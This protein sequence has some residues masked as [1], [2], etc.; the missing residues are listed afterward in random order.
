MND[1]NCRFKVG[2]VV[3]DGLGNDVCIVAVRS[4]HAHRHPIVGLCGMKEEIKSYSLDGRYHYSFEPSEHD[5][6]PP[7]R[8]VYLNYYNK[9]G[10]GYA[11]PTKDGAERFSGEDA[12]LVAF[13]VELPE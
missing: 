9:R 3:K 4:G 11:Y 10:G 12:D 2:D 7:K 1:N 8:V 13:P 6:I 5:L